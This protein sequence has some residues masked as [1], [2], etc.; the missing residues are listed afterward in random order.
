MV[1]FCSK[2]LGTHHQK[3]SFWPRTNKSDL[4]YAKAYPCLPSLKLLLVNL[5]QPI[6]YY[7]YILHLH[8]FLSTAKQAANF[9]GMRWE[10]ISLSYKWVFLSRISCLNEN[11]SQRKSLGETLI[12]KAPDFLASLPG[13]RLCL[14]HFE[15][16]KLTIQCPWLFTVKM[17]L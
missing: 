5:F 1:P 16:E 8:I 3:M 12:I 9:V 14:H 10:I 17:L 4:Q 6:I 15:G 13:W 11:G 2:K 7:K